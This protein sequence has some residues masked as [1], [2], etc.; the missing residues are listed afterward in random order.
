M[1]DSSFAL[2]VGVWFVIRG[3]GGLTSLIP[4]YKRLMRTSSGALHIDS[5]FLILNSRVE[6]VMSAREPKKKV[7][8][9]R[10]KPMMVRY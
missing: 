9:A 4:Q 2:P 3:G 6:R 8:V 5:A 7:V 1:L 10:D